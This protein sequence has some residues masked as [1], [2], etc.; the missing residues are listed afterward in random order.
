MKMGF[1][2]HAICVTA[3]LERSNVM[4]IEAQPVETLCATESG[5]ALNVIGES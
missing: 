3:S 2:G 1:K 5:I 4:S